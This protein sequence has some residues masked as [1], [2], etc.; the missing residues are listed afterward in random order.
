MALSDG[1]VVIGLSLLQ[2]SAGGGA[3]DLSDLSEI[4]GGGGGRGG[5]GRSESATPESN[6]RFRHI[7]ELPVFAMLDDEDVWLFSRVNVCCCGGAFPAYT[8]QGQGPAKSHFE[9]LSPWTH[10]CD[11]GS[12]STQFRWK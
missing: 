3:V 5:G 10:N 8:A 1:E 4:D 7:Q 9:F 12:W 6:S 11:L 2:N